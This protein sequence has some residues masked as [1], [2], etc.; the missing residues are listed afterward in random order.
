M[1]RSA[2]LKSA[3]SQ[4]VLYRHARGRSAFTKIVP[5][6]SAWDRSAPRRF[7]LVKFTPLMSMYLRSA[8][9]R[10][11]PTRQ[12][13]LITSRGRAIFLRLKEIL[14]GFLG[15]RLPKTLTLY[16]THSLWSLAP[17]CQSGFRLFL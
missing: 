5:R 17:V 4:F 10:F 3:S 2:L 13:C 14:C 7:E 9:S 15:F 6:Q 8:R 16:F 11:V 1:V 12:Q